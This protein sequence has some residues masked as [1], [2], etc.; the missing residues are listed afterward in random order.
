MDDDRLFGPA[1]ASRLERLKW[2]LRKRIAAGSE[3]EKA[4]RRKGGLI[5]FA[6]HR[7]YAPGDDLRY[8]DWNAYVRLNKLAVKEFAKE[9]EVPITLLLDVSGSMGAPGPGKF[10][11]ACRA[12]AALAY[13]G[14]ASHNPVRVMA[15]REAERSLSRSFRGTE[16]LFDLMEWLKRLTPSGGTGLAQAL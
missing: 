5:E 9:E 15:F 1:F 3:G 7:D 11:L 12:T 10:E 13:I 2:V 4:G 6:D 16:A 14:L 8:V